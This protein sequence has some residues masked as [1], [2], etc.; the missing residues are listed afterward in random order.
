[1]KTPKTEEIKLP[2]ASTVASF[3]KDQGAMSG[4]S[5]IGKLAAGGGRTIQS[6]PGVPPVS[7]APGGAGL[8]QTSPKLGGR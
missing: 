3:Y 2:Y 5:F 4:K 6:R 1:M 7:V 8:H